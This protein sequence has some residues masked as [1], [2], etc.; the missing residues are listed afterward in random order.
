MSPAPAPAALP[1]TTTNLADRLNRHCRCYRPDIAA[2][3]AGAASLLGAEP[4]ARL[5]SA[6]ALYS[7]TVAF[8]D[9]SQLAELRA[10]ITLI[11]RL[12]QTPEW[13]AAH[14]LPTPDPGQGPGLL[15]GY[16]FHITAEGCRLIEINTNA[17][18]AV[19]SAL[20]LLALKDCCERARVWR[21]AYLRLPY[22]AEDRLARILSLPM[23]EWQQLRGPVP[24][25]RVA[26]VDADPAAQA[27]YPEFLAYAEA[28]RRGGVECTIL[29]PADLRFVD[30]ELI[31]PTGP[32]DFV[33]NRLTDFDF[34][35]PGNAALAAA[36]THGR[37]LISP[38]PALYRRLAD[39]R[40]LITLSDPTALARLPLDRA[41]RALLLR[42]V[43]TT[44]A[45][46]SFDPEA[47]WA[48]R[49]RWFF[50]PATGYGSRAAYRGEK[51]TRRVYAELAT[52]PGIVQQ[53][54]QPAARH[55]WLSD[56]ETDL[57]WDLRAYTWN[58]ELILLSARLY[59]GQTT[60]FRTRGGGFAPVLVVDRG[61]LSPPC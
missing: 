61:A 14:E 24:P 40:R 31:G 26:I 36:W 52:R 51:L 11:E 10:A 37:V 48:E 49:A 28:I 58:G 13:S 57:K 29:D 17:G 27:L 12:A 2:A 60:N 1:W 45:V 34:A 16:D 47:L 19:P 50:K 30:G 59:Q 22:P 9:A 8:V 55:V 56:L 7:E 44:R 5:A 41:E 6:S 25:R 20:A 4:F 43:P 46:S 39:K 3:A 38:H 42:V 35:E 21:E 23:Q 32:I 15:M 33:Y 18:G 53:L 54:V